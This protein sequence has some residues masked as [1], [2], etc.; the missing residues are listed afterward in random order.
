MKPS[1]WFHRLCVAG[2][3]AFM[4]ISGTVHSGVAPLQLDLYDA[5]DNAL[6]FVKFYY[7]VEERN[8][9]REVY[10]SDSTFI[11]KVLIVYDENG[12]RSQEISYNFNDD[13]SFVTTYKHD[14]TTTGFSVVDQFK[15][16]Q[17]GGMVNYETADP[18]NFDLKYEKSGASAVKVAYQEDEEGQLE[19]VDVT[20][21]DGAL[22]YYGKFTNA[23]VA[24]KQR[25]KTAGASVPAIVQR[26]GGA[27]V[28]VLFNLPI[29]R[30][31]RCELMAVN[32]RRVAEL[33]N[34]EVKAGVS[35][36]RFRL[37]EA[38]V[39]VAASGVYLLIVSLDGVT[40][41]SSKFLYQ[42]IAA[43]GVR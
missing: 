26:R 30:T 23:E 8:I 37:N 15:I 39:P 16:D 41:S 18:L 5:A 33:F 12:K 36:K 9:V 17:V 29:Q 31:V 25:R 34:G 20:D 19:R 2:V 28:D 38:G 43:G 22:L 13:T 42:H 7:D 24:V 1:S 35:T 32:G 11:R 4:T 40:V 10:M 14:G 6:M 21:D 27:L 3:T